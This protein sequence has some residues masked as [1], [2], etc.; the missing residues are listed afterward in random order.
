MSCLS[1]HSRSAV[2]TAP[3]K[4]LV[5]TMFAALTDQNAGNS[6][7]RC[8]KLTD[9]SR[10]FVITMSRR[11]QLTSSYGCRPAVVYTRSTRSPCGWNTG[12]TGAGALFEVPVVSTASVI[13]LGPFED[14]TNRTGRREAA[15]M[16]WGSIV[17]GL[18]R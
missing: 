8:S 14:G 13:A 1:D 3:R 12:R 10:Q 18:G 2:P 7:P 9:P 5:V 11:S 16:G 17:G 6:T 15:G 4:Y